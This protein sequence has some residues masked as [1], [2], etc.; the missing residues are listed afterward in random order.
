MAEGSLTRLLE[1]L[2]AEGR[3][4]RKLTSHGMRGGYVLV[5]RSWGILNS[6]IAWEGNQIGGVKTLERSYDGVP[7][8]WSAISN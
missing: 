2:L 4:K 1:D 8:H 6:Q 3:I 5:R 7:P